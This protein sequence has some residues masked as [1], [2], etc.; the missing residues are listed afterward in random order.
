MRKFILFA[1][2]LSLPLIGCGD[3]EVETTPDAGSSADS[4]ADV[5]A[6]A[7]SGDAC[8]DVDVA[9]EV[10]TECGGEIGGC[11]EGAQCSML[12]ASAEAGICRQLC[13][14][15]TC[16]SVCAD[17]EIC[18]PL[19]GSPGTGVCAVEPTGSQGPY[20]VCSVA[21]GLCSEGLQ[22]AG[23]PGGS[24]SGICIPPC[25]EHADCPDHDG[26]DGLCAVTL[27]DTGQRYC[28]PGCSE[29]GADEECPGLTVCQ[30]NGPET[31]CAFPQ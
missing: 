20:E 28:M 21:D 13:L 24:E 12:E 30:Q 2:L 27:P 26:H 22:C 29:A 10:G 5:T 18:L 15:D 4:G 17:D 19:T 9:D 11:L 8:E 3:D 23:A 7:G 25:T 6:D 1:A 16:E 14:P 31:V